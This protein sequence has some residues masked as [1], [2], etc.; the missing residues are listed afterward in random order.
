MS[1]SIP[2]KVVV[3]DYGEVISVTP[4]EAEQLEL[5]AMT[6][7]DA[8]VFWPLY[9]EHRP[10]LD[11]GVILPDEYWRIIGSGIGR[12]FSP[13]ETQALWVRD[14]RS[15]ISVEPATIE[16]LAELR[17]GGTRMA[18]LSNAGFDFADP[19]RYSP[20]GRFFE[21]VFVSAE[22]GL[23]KPDPEIYRVTAAELGIDPADMVFID[24]KLENVQGAETL[25]VTGHH[26]T[27]A[28]ALRAFLRSIAA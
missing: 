20:M 2:G 27:G 19:F 11:Q 7:A 15:W 6:G 5:L 13:A 3:F 14:F 1:I 16:V 12:D 23:L 25:E 4:T 18:I 17:A 10:P 24:N 9:W 26:F 21:R 22:L 8:E 28:P